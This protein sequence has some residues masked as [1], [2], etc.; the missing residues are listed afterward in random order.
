M[1]MK[2]GCMNRSDGIRAYKMR[3]L[4]AQPINKASPGIGSSFVTI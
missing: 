4:F 2:Y 1:R 3:S